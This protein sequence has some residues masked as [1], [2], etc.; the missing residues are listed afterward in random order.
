MRKASQCD[1]LKNREVT[2]TAEHTVLKQ[3][4][5][6]SLY[7]ISTINLSFCCCKD[8]EYYY[9]CNKIILKIR[10]DAMKHTELQSYFKERVIELFHKNTLDSYRVRSHNAF[11]LLKELKELIIGW[12][13]NRIK[14]FETVQLCI[15]ETKDSISQ[16]ECLDF[17]F[18][19]KICF[20]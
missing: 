4:M 9:I 15:Q 3:R 2:Q 19:A 14:Q 18:T 5:M 12:K 16:D 13:R 11:S 8:S 1:A 10:I 6:R 17:S 7:I 20:Y